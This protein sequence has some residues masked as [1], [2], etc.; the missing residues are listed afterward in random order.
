[1]HIHAS[2]HARKNLLGCTHS[3]TACIHSCMHACMQCKSVHA[4]MCIIC[5]KLHACMHEYTFCMHAYMHACTNAFCMHAE[6]VCL[7]CFCCF[8][9][10]TLSWRYFQAT[11]LI[12]AASIAF[13]R[14]KNSAIGT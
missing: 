1:M 3:N 11:R 14:I 5:I 7:L 13:N 12:S 9:C 8:L 4:L 6:R 2:I 10:F